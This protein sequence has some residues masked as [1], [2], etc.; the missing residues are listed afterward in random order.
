MTSDCS[1][2]V[3]PSV[4]VSVRDGNASF[5]SVC[6]NSECERNGRQNLTCR[7]FLGIFWW[8]HFFIR[9]PFLSADSFD[10]FTWSAEIN[11]S[12]EQV[13]PQQA[14][15]SAFLDTFK[16]GGSYSEERQKRKVLIFT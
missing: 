11:K 6:S 14:N 8:N 1:V 3:A 15:F 4:R 10:G 5:V 16:K 7:M 9:G 12:C 2:K 13:I